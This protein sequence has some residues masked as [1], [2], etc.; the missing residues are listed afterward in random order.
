MV[1]QVGGE[2]IAENPKACL[3]LVFQSVASILFR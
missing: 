1:E 2:A 3:A